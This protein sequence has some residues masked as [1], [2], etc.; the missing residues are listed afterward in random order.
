MGRGDERVE[1]MDSWSGYERASRLWRARI[2][3]ALDPHRGGYS[4]GQLDRVRIMARSD[5]A[6]YMTDEEAA[7]IVASHRK[8]ASNA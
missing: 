3:H 2:L 1:P 7:V 5:G 4:V 8:G 6:D